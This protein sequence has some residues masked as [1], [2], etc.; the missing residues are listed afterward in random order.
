M[1]PHNELIKTHEYQ[2]EIVQNR[3]ATILQTYMHDFNMNEL[4]VSEFVDVPPSYIINAAR[5][6]ILKLD[7]LIIIACKLGIDLKELFTFE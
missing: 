1:K 5:G 3:L 7:I 4:A 2:F 6:R